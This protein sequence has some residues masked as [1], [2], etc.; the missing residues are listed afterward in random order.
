MKRNE[1]NVKEKKKKRDNMN[2]IFALTTDL[3]A[4]NKIKKNITL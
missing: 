1:K 2:K 3:S 4:L